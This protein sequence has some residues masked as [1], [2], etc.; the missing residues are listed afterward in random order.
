VP[1]VR[2]FKSL[3]VPI[4]INPQMPQLPDFHQNSSTQPYLCDDSRVAGFNQYLNDSPS[5]Y[6][7]LRFAV[8]ALSE[9]S[10]DPPDVQ[11]LT[12]I[13]EAAL[14]AQALLFTASLHDPDESELHRFFEAF[15]LD[16]VIPPE[17]RS[18]Q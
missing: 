14:A 3:D 18:Y 2:T 12:L 7:Y 13:V 5:V 10:Q 4:L 9:Y 1:R 15:V 11:R 8:Q 6:R 17:K 16:C